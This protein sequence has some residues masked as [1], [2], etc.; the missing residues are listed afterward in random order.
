LVLQNQTVSDTVR[1]AG[2][3]LTSWTP[4]DYA[5]LNN[6]PDLEGR[7]TIYGGEVHVDGPVIGNAY[8]GYS[9]VKASNI[10]SVADGVQ[11]LHGA[12][13]YGFAVNYF[14]P[15]TNPQSPLTP[16]RN[17][18]GTVDTLLGQ[19]ILHFAPL[20]GGITKGPDAALAVYGMLNHVKG[21]FFT[22]DKVKFGTELLV[23][24][25]RY[26]S[27]GGRFDRV[28]P[29]GSNNTAVGYSAISPR[30]I[31]HT[32]FLSREYVVIDYTHFSL[33]PNV[34]ASA[35]Y[36]VYPIPDSDLFSITALMSF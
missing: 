16:P 17:D 29:D 18:S 24:P 23:S 8:L 14:G 20:V 9:H 32:N 6:G 7:M 33:G 31:V 25:I 27:L 5:D 1:I 19:Y 10:M 26:V 30:V 35:P 15:L 28:L 36:N 3:Y 22:T 2:H 12:N 11:V 4:N 21:P 34:R 13:G